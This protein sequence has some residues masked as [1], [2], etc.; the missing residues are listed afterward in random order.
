MK[1]KDMKKKLDEVLKDD[2]DVEMLNIFAA[3][4]ERIEPHIRDRNGSKMVR[5]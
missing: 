3:H 2:D 1:W 5:W 4:I